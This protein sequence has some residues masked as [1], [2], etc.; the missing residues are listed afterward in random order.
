VPLGCSSAVERLTVNQIVAGSIPAIPVV[1]VEKLSQAPLTITGN[2]VIL[3]G[4]LRGE[5]IDLSVLPR[6]ITYSFAHKVLLSIIMGSE[7]G[8]RQLYSMSVFVW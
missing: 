7:V 8:L 1:P 2:R 4:W 6:G 3:Q 5:D